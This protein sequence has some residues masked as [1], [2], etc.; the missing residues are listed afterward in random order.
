MNIVFVVLHYKVASITK[1]CLE[2]L[3]QQD[4]EKF[5]I[6]VIDNC[7]KNGSYEELL[8]TY[9]NNKKIYFVS[10]E[11]NL[12]FAKAND[13]GYQI[14]KHKFSANCIVVINNDLFIKDK[15]FCNI[16]NNINKI[17]DF[18]ILGPN[19]INKNGEHQNPLINC[20]IEKKDVCR[21][22]NKTRL[23]I[24]LIPLLYGLTKRKGKKQQISTNDNQNEKMENVP[25]HGS[26]LIFGNKF[27]N[28]YEYPFYPNTF[29]YGE[30]DILFYQA[31]KRGIRTLYYPDLIV[32]HIEDVST[33]EVTKDNK[34]K[35]LF[36]LKNSLTSLLILKEL[37]EKED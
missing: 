20:A 37:M 29:L 19:I 36:E 30:E 32:H 23:K 6:I 22:I 15:Q 4:Y 13:L 10:I 3:M 25:L 16:L 1:M 8:N 12:G 27:I 21:L 17:E 2:Y 5:E 18:E 24:K 35:R 33:E 11:H 28:K 34:E 31:R 14:A 26:C 9:Y 7:S